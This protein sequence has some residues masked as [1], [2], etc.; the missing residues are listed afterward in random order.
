M[1]FELG[2]SNVLSMNPNLNTK[3]KLR[4]SDLSRGKAEARLRL[5]FSGPVRLL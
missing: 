3:A 1:R 2:C 4:E 5:F